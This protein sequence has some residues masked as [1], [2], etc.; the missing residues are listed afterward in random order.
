METEEDVM[1]E[2]H[3]VLGHVP[4]AIAKE[5]SGRTARSGALKVRVGEGGESTHLSIGAG[6]IL[7]V[8]LGPSKNGETSV[9]V[10]VREDT[11]LEFVVEGTP[12]ELSLRQIPDFGLTRLRPPINSIFY[13]PRQVAQLIKSA[14]AD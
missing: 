14:S 8:L 10:F 5:W 6:D 13:D 2:M 11:K 4:D 9:Q 3:A 1:N 7:G 12:S